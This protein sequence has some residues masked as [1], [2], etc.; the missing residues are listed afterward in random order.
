MNDL[1]FYGGL[2]VAFCQLVVGANVTIQRGRCLWQPTVH[3]AELDFLQCCY[4]H[5]QIWDWVWTYKGI[6]IYNCSVGLDFSS[7]GSTEQSVGSITF[8]DSSITNTPVGFITHTAQHHCPLLGKFDSRECAAEQ[9]SYR[10]S[11]SW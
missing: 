6:N 2:Q 9:C 11:R 10:G 5:D 1:V 8:I 4:C 7:G 3:H